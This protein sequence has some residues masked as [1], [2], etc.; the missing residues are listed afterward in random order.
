LLFSFFQFSGKRP[1][2]NRVH[3][4]FADQAALYGPILRGEIPFVAKFVILTDANDIETMFR[5]EE[6]FPTRHFLGPV[7]HY[8]EKLSKVKLDHCGLLLL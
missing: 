6:K 5:N 8:R 7:K 4:H 3:E 2:L 1:D